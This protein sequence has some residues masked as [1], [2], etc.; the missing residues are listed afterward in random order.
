MWAAGVKDGLNIIPRHYGT[1]E[2]TELVLKQKR[3][4][5]QHIEPH[6]L[7]VVRWTTMILGTN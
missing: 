2:T 5:S 4:E 3:D 1:L 6:L 7:S